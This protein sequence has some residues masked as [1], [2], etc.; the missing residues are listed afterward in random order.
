L[1]INGK[2]KTMSKITEAEEKFCMFKLGMEGS[3]TTSLI[4]TI[5]KGDIINRAKLAEGFPDLVTVVNDYNNTSGY[6][7]DLINR[8]NEQYPTRKLYY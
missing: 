1:V 6:W 4:E 7:Q 3:F 2:I 5:F 8:W